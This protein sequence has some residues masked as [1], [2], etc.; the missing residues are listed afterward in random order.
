MKTTRKTVAIFIALV[1]LLALFPASAF[2][3]T[4]NS[5]ERVISLNAADVSEIRI[6]TVGNT[7][8]HYTA[9]DSTYH[10]VG[11]SREKGDAVVITGTSQGTTSKG[12]IIEASCDVILD[13]VDITSSRSVIELRPG[14]SATLYL[15]E[16]KNKITTISETAAAIQTTGATLII[17]GKGSLT[18]TGGT[19]GAAIGGSGGV[20]GLP[21]LPALY[22]STSPT[23]TMIDSASGGNGGNG[24]GAGSIIIK[25]GIIKAIGN[26]GAGIGS[27]AGGLGGPAVTGSYTTTPTKFPNMGFASGNGGNGGNGGIGGAV[28]I[29]GGTIT[30]KS[31]YGAGIGGG[32]GGGGSDGGYGITGH[33]S[34]CNG[35][36][37]GAGGYIS[38]VTI[39]GGTVI[40][41]SGN[42]LLFGLTVG[43]VSAGIGGASGGT[44]GRGGVIDG[45]DITFVSGNAGN[46]GNGGGGATFTMS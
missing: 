25:S 35:G 9:V 34:G 5:R 14:V 1:M 44:G 7:N 33:Q 28:A 41:E 17:D 36:N 19:Y 21:G 10:I 40:A 2:A 27:G 8:W 11:G 42:F 6:N 4:V 24:N 12:I 3:A 13:G 20:V 18:A 26:Y 30:A 38:S 37:G 32:A 29:E 15:T 16:S 39:K 46:A 45:W 22:I 31:T 43:G 23:T